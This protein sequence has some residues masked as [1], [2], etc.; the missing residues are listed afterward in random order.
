MHT[1]L[2][3]FLIALV[4]I[5]AG[6]T[7]YNEVQYYFGGSAESGYAENPFAD[8][9]CTVAGINIHGD[10]YTYYDVESMSVD[11][12]ISSEYVQYLLEVAEYTPH[13]E[14]ILLEIDSYGGMPVAA[15][16]IVS[17]INHTVS[18]PVI[19]QIRGAGLSAA[20]WVA[21]AADVVFASELSDVGAIGVT[22]S[23]TDQSTANRQSG[24]TF[25]SLS[26]GKFKDI[27][28]PEK[29]LT[30]E[31]RRILERDLAITHDVFVRSVAENR[32][33]S[34]GEVQAL[35]DGSSM[36]GSLA[37]EKG[38]IDEI[39]DYYD[40]LSYIK[41]NYGFDPIVCYR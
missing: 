33:M 10:I 34:V 5:A 11:D 7:I 4:V 14:A 21:S 25:N 18:V 41:E 13:I 31:E 17:A 1:G 3:A 40:V 23:Y 38:L 32:G 28:N 8:S 19:A 37:K 15:H 29:P 36:L 12:V 20:Y 16:E 2:K 35:S 30:Y 39:G 24:I 27:L 26:T 9:E 6:I 22:Q